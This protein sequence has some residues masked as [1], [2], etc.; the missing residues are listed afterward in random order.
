MLIPHQKF[1]QRCLDLALKGVGNVAPNPMVGAVL[2]YKDKIIG[3]GYHE[4][5]G[6]AHAEVN[7]INSVAEAEQ[8]LISDS[9]LYVSLE[10]C[11]HF[12]KTPPCT[13]LILANKIPRVVIGSMDPFKEVNGKG[14][15]MLRQNGVE[16]IG[17]VLED[18]ANWL[19]RRFILFHKKKRPN[20]ILKWAE[21]ADG[22][23]GRKD[24]EI[25]ISNS[26]TQKLVHRWRMEEAAILVGTQTALT[27]NPRLDN[28]YF[29][30]PSPI[31]MVIDR[32][33]T[34]LKQS[35][36]LSDGKPTI[37][38]N[39]KVS[40]QE[41]AVQY[42]QLPQANSWVDAILDF[43]Y[44]QQIQSILVE[45]GASLLQSFL[46]ADCWDEIRVIKSAD[47]IKLTSDVGV[48]APVLKGLLPDSIESVG[49][50]SVLYFKR[51]DL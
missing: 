46:D 12:G 37:V 43:A 21:S 19:N 34:L 1:M 23:I 17:P 24:A 44:Q 35:N 22:W 13:N 41:G 42:V 28:R 49:N 27:D 31:R 10:P 5:Y 51:K 4:I 7:C 3:E 20:I 50:N 32:K 16:V 33:G 9:T 6:Q 18:E 30:G 14:I 25:S 29:P 45:G 40:K 15:A 48:K 26:F 38:F 47:A 39:E 8:H 2:V 36:L 11:S